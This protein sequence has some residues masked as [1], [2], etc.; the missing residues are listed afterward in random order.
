MDSIELLQKIKHQHDYYNRCLT[1]SLAAVIGLVGLGLWWAEV[2][3]LDEYKIAVGLVMIL[4]AF[5]FFNIPY[6]VYRLMR[7]RYRGDD[8]MM[9]LIGKRWYFYKVNII[10]R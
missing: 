5:I 1:L 9:Q 8:R 10:N 3:L 7:R 6:F 2:P 4:L